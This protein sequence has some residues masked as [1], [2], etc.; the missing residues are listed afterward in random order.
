MNRI[1]VLMYHHIAP[2]PGDTV[3]VTPEVFAG[4]MRLLAECGYRFLS[5]AELVGHVSGNSPVREKSVAITFDDGWLDNYLN[6]YPVLELLGIKATIF[7]ITGRADA[8]S[9]F[10][11]SLS[12]EVPVHEVAKM[13]I[14][15]GHAERVVL[16]WET[17]RTMA[18][19]GLV[20]FHSHTVSHRRCAE[21]SSAELINELT[22]SKRSVEQ[23]LGCSCDYLCWPYGSYSDHA[24][25]IA[26]EA[27]YRALFTIVDG[28]CSSGSDPMR[29]CRVDVRNSVESLQLR[30]A[31]G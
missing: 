15:E 20:T 28:F 21:L 31:A 10:G 23:E 17:I 24:V 16:D 3:T 6:A 7:V 4:Q 13:H 29:I 25:K 26:R 5:A 12:V 1:P 19:G 14:R 18:S 8:A 22:E 2:H 27:G 30:L 9:R 11:C